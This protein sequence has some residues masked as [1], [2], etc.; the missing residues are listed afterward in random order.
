MR[1]SDQRIALQAVEF[2]STVC[3]EEIDIMQDAEEAAEYGEAPTR[4]NQN[5]ANAAL[6]DIVPVLL[7]LLTKQDEDADEDEWNEAMAAGTCLSLL[8]Q[9]VRDNIVAPVVPFVEQNVQNQDW[10]FREA[11]VMAFGKIWL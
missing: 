2:W 11:A 7:W 5:F 4:V 1:H 6:Q 10:R 9:C 3:D 8:A